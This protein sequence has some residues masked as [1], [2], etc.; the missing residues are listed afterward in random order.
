MVGVGEEGEALVPGARRWRSEG[1][2]KAETEK[3]GGHLAK[4]RAGRRGGRDR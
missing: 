2:S 3:T 1:A 4:T